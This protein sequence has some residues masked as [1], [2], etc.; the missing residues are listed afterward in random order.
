MRVTVQ[1]T[2]HAT[3]MQLDF[4]RDAIHKV[5]FKADW[6]YIKQ[7]RQHVIHQNNKHENSKRTPHTYKVGDLVMVFQ[8]QNHKY[9]QPRFKGPYKVDDVYDN[10]TLSLFHD[11]NRGGAI[12]Q[13]WNIRQVYPYKN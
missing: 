9:G 5:R 1:T 6:Q 11:T 10:G 2:Q 13:T 7:R 3:P 8:Y 4:N 12:N